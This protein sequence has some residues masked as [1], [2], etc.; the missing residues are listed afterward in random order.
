MFRVGDKVRCINNVCA[1]ELEIGKIYTV[2]EDESTH[3]I[4]FENMFCWHPS[5]F[6]LDIKYTRKKKLSKIL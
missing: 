6:I 4:L 1:I 3:V 5:R 2:R